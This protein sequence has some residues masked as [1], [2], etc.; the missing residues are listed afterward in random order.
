MNAIGRKPT[1][2]SI[3]LAKP[4]LIDPAGTGTQPERDPLEDAERCQRRDDRGEA[5]HGREE[6]VE[7]AEADPAA[8]IARMPQS[9]RYHSDPSGIVYEAMTTPI[10][11]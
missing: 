6:D 3:A 2:F 1:L 11:I 9:N 8:I 10:V 5:E 4:W 7:H